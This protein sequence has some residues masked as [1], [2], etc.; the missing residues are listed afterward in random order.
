MLVNLTLPVVN[1]YVYLQSL[2]TLSH[3][4]PTEMIQDLEELSISLTKSIT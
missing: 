3:D 1:V 2:L 4:K